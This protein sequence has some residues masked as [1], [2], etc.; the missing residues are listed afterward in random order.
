[1]EDPM[2]YAKSFLAAFVLALAVFAG[3]PVPGGTDSSSVIYIGAAGQIEQVD[4]YVDSQGNI[5]AV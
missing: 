1:M 5:V 3:T 2:R 4:I